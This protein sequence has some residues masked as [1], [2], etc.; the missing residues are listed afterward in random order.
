MPIE[1][2]DTMDVR[3]ARAADA[4]CIAALFVQLGYE[5]AAQDVE[6]RLQLADCDTLVAVDG[7]TVLGVL[8]MHRFAPL[9]VARPWT[10]ISSLVVDE[11]RRSHG[12]GAALLAH[13]ES[14]A[15]AHGCAHVELAC[16]ERRTRAH[17]FYAA[18]GFE[19]VRKRLVKR[20]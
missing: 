3:P 10:V 15:V 1:S 11:T 8:V 9:H 18:H 12:A 20:L 7:D 14:A 19:E 6:R 17:A 2:F 5:S 4:P 16:S 13:A